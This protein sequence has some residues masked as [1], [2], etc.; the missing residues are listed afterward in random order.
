MD[1]LAEAIHKDEDTGAAFGVTWEAED[2]VHA[3]GSP[4]ARGDG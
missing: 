4:H 3:D 2:E 1:H